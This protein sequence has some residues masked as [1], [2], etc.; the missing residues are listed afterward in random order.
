M[1]KINIRMNN[2]RKTLPVALVF[3]LVFHLCLGTIGYMKFFKFKIITPDLSGASSV[4]LKNRIR[5]DEIKFISKNDLKKLK[6]SNFLNRQ[7]V[8]SESSDRAEKVKESRFLGE[9]NQAFDR[10][11]LARKNGAFKEA[12]LGKR[13]ADLIKEIEAVKQMKNKV[14]NTNKSV[15]GLPSQKILSLNDFGHFKMSEVEKI[16]KSEKYENTKTDESLSEK[17]EKNKTNLGAEN[18]KRG[19]AGLSQSSDFVEDVPL[20]DMT[21]LNTTEFKYYG[22]YHRIRQK[23]EQHWGSTIKAKARNLYRSG[24]RL[25]ESEN[26]ITSLTVVLDHVGNIVD[27]QIE[28][29]SGVKELDQA[30]IDSFN[31]AGPFPNPPKGLMVDGRAKI[32]WGFVVKS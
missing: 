16:M 24:R 9:K 26:L 14:S 29:T 20:G 3:S 7:I 1:N 13:D 30:A 18:G 12:G 25:P 2:E 28:G 32:Q 27:M 22:F 5:L 21:Q 8:A 17:F 6:N 15:V 11:T 19:V 4:Q 31:K 23:L 10:Q